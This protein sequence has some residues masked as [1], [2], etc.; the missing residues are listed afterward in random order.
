LKLL[1]VTCIETENPQG[2]K[3]SSLQYSFCKVP[4]SLQ[5]L[6]SMQKLVPCWEDEEGRAIKP[7]PGNPKISQYSSLF[8]PFGSL[9]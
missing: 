5:Y 3:T 6:I 1:L 4:C 2:I 8:H 9:S 7:V